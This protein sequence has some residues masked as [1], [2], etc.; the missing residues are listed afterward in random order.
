MKSSNHL[1]KTQIHQ[2]YIN[3]NKIYESKGSN[4]ILWFDYL[5][6]IWE[7]VNQI[8]ILALLALCF[9]YALYTVYSKWMTLAKVHVL[10]VN[11][12]PYPLTTQGKMIW[13]CVSWVWRRRVWPGRG[14]RR[15]C[16]GSLKKSGNA[17][18]EF[19][20]SR[21]PLRTSRPGPHTPPPC[22]RV[23]SSEP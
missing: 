11:L 9:V 12:C 13:R 21:K 18:M 4:K 7:Y 2:R 8:T 15:S 6:D 10:S 22:S 19:S 5:I 17:A 14:A 23:S 1:F 16:P 20:T 3:I